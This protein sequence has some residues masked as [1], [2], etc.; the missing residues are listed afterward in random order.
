MR[1]Y[2]SN[3]KRE[4][5]RERQKAHKAN[6]QDT[7]NCGNEKQKGPLRT[8]H[9]GLPFSVRTSGSLPKVDLQ[10]EEIPFWGREMGAKILESHTCPG[11]ISLD[12]I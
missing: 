4:K 6:D 2:K 12:C 10:Q 5:K 1:P 11:L 8:S 3:R 9:R 7:D